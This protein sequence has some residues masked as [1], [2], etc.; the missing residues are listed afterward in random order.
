[1]RR[2]STFGAGRGVEVSLG[3]GAVTNS[4]VN[5]RRKHAAQLALLVGIAWL[6]GCSTVPGVLPVESL[7]NGFELLGRA[8]IRHGD[9]AA[10]VSVQWRHQATGDDMLITNAM[11][12]GVARI[13]RADSAVLLETSDGRRFRSTDAETLTEQVLG[14]R[15]PLSGLPYWLRARSAPNREARRVLEA[16]GRLLHLEQD[17]WQIEYQEYR[18]ERPVRMRLSRPNLEIRLIVDSWREAVP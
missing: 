3:S 11:G 15:V 18:D 17:A 5:S 1:M 10:S 14:W 8:A 4:V 13:S 6:A 9:D 16:N 2:C 12:Q 7:T